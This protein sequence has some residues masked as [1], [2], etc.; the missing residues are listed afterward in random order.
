[1]MNYIK[2]E[3]YRV[4]H[5]H[6]VYSFTGILIFIAVLLNTGIHFWGNQYAI[7]SFSYSNFVAN[8]IIFVIMGTVTAYL[9]YEGNRKNGNLKNTVASG[10]PRT[11]IFIGECIV[12]ILTATFIMILA[13]GAW[14]IS[15][16]LLLDR[17]GPVALK[18]LL[19]EVPA[20]YLISLAGLISGIFFLERF[21]KN[22]VGILAWIFIW[23]LFP[24][25]LMYLGM[26]FDAVHKIAMWLPNNFFGTING[27]NVNMSKC[28]TI[29]D[30]ADGW[31]KCIV[32]GTIGVVVFLLAGLVSLRKRDL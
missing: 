18:D 6:G 14:I 26:R 15:A 20:V 5:T 4:S 23:F 3:L 11:R 25:F 21:E 29:W 10:I 7:T 2:S 13:L 27:L 24:N 12:S 31:I 19:L 17:T 32:S 22:T 30:T 8:P 9:L 28:I 1:M 16:E